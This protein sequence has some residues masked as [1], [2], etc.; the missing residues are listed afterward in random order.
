MPTSMIAEDVITIPRLREFLAG[1]DNRYASPSDIKSYGLS[2]SGHTV[3]I[4]EGGS[5]TSVTIPD[6]DTTYRA[7][8]NNEID[9]AVSAA[10]S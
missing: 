5:T 8:N 6:S 9:A 1:C 7:M 2:I 10:L 3:S 4:V